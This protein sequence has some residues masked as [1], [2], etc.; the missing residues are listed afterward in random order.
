M[1]N[2]KRLL[3]E[4]GDKNEIFDKAVHEG[5]NSKKVSRYLAKNPDPEESKK[6]NLINNILVGIYVILILLSIP[7]IA[8]DFYQLAPLYDLAPLQITIIGSIILI[9]IQ[10]LIIYSIYKKI[11][12]GY[13]VVFLSQAL[14]IFLLLQS[15]L[16]VSNAAPKISLYCN[17]CFTHLDSKIKKQ[18]FSLSGFLSHG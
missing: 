16:T 9:S 13:I 4:G 7:K 18:T 12:Y 8:I 1:K 17:R 10:L 5:L 6:H 15:C 14:S 11:A 2:I 3:K